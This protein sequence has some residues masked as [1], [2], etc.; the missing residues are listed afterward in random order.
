MVEHQSGMLN[1][2]EL[3]CDKT[4]DAIL[5]DEEVGAPMECNSEQTL[6]DLDTEDWMSK[7]REDEIFNGPNGP[8]PKL[9]GLRRLAKPYIQQENSRVNALIVVPKQY[10]HV[11]TNTN[12]EGDIMSQHEEI[13]VYHFPMAS[14]TF[15]I[16]LVDSRTFSDSADAFYSS[17]EKLGLFPTAVASARAE[18][19]CLRKVLGISE[20]SAE[21]LVDKDAGEELVPDDDSPIKPEQGKLIDKMLKSL[22]MSLKELLEEITIREVFSVE[23]LTTGE[24]R[25]ALRL[26]NDYKKKNKKKAKKS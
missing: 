12:G 18:A 9:K 21:E 5:G 19:R 7:L 15:T 24:A 16:T 23:E 22:D 8:A 2:I 13:G 20:H 6:P 3:S 11:L 1:K 25:K 17:C 10:V 26:L 4:V 14:V